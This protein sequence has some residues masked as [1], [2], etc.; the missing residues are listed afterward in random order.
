MIS[1]RKTGLKGSYNVDFYG[2]LFFRGRIVVFIYNALRRTLFLL[3]Y[4]DKRVKY[5]GRYRTE[6]LFTRRFY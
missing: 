6:E 2:A 5:L 4:D 1:I 3:Y